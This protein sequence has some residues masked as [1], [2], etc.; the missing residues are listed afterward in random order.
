MVF[1]VSDYRHGKE[2]LIRHIRRFNNDVTKLS[3]YC[4]SFSFPVAAAIVFCIEE[5][6][7]HR[8]ALEMNLESIK[9]FYG[10]KSIEE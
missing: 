8:E 9:T 2:D 1:K 10:Y 4:A 7:E 6:P 5:F 3:Y